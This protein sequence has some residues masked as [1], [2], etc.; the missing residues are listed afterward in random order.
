MFLRFAD[1]SPISVIV[2]AIFNIDFA[3]VRI[4]LESIIES[5]TSLM[6]DS[7]FW[8]RFRALLLL[9]LGSYIYSHVSPSSVTT[10]L[11]YYNIDPPGVLETTNTNRFHDSYDLSILTEDP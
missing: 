8:D 11:R 10:V 3:F 9:A 5:E 7:E 2:L 1:L 4:D 6:I